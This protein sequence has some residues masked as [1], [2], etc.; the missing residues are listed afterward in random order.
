MIIQS[1]Q[2]AEVFNISKYSTTKKKENE[3]RKQINFSTFAK[4]IEKNYPLFLCPKKM[5]VRKKKLI[6]EK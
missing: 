6:I 4:K 1:S 3:T 2:N 5:Q